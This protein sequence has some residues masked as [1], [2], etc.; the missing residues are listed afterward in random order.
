MFDVAA[1]SF[2]RIL[3]LI[4]VAAMIL[5]FDSCTPIKNYPHNVPFVYQPPKINIIGDYDK[6]LKKD[7]I[8]QL[9]NQV[10]DSISPRR[11]RILF[12]FRQLNKP[13]VFDTINL[14]R[15]IVF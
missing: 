7:L 13:P 5:F 9:E 3:S 12:F 1:K 8:S 10:H 6:D 15:S 2:V 4:A 11:K 14:S